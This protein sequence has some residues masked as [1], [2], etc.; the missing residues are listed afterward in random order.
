MIALELLLTRQQDKLSKVLPKRAEAFLGWTGL[1]QSQDYE[2]RIKDV[3][4]KRNKLMHTGEREIISK[5][6]LLFTDDLL[7]NLF[8]N[9]TKMPDLFASKEKIIEFAE[10]VEAEHKLRIKSKVQPGKLRFF[11]RKYSEKDFNEI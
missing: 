8:A 1:W 6:D 5:R 4:E 3:Y 2:A 11:S 10:K 9:L 7:L